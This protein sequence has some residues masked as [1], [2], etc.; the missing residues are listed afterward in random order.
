MMRF[1]LSNLVSSAFT[2]FY[3]GSDIGRSRLIKNAKWAVNQASIN[4]QDVARTPVPIP[5][6]E[7]QLEIVKHVKFQLEAYQN[8]SAA[9]SKLLREASAQH[10]NLLKAAFTGQL[11]PQDPADEPASVLIERI[12]AEREAN[13]GMKRPRGRRKAV[14]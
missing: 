12:R 5:P 11:V 6:Q 10:K 9:I 13:S 8:L 2:T 7:E 3:L 1:R 4:Q 14:A